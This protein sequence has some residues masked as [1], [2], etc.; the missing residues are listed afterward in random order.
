[1]EDKNSTF[2]EAESIFT[3][4]K[5]KEEIKD[6]PI[7]NGLQIHKKSRNDSRMDVV[8][9]NAVCNCMD[10]EGVINSIYFEG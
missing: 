5:T 3:F 2:I 9:S 10:K 1:M 8:Y 6:L 4:G 7:I